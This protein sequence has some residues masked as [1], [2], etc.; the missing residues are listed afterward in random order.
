[1]KAIDEDN[2]LSMLATA[3]VNLSTVRHLFFC[4]VSA[5]WL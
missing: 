2:T 4:V 1:M 5:L 3:W